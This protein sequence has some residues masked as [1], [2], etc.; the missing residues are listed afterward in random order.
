MQSPNHDPV[1]SLTHCASVYPESHH[2]PHV[3]EVIQDSPLVCA[4]ANILKSAELKLHPLME[5]HSIHRRSIQR[6]HSKHNLLNL[7]LK[8][9]LHLQKASP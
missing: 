6:A 4:S 1:D 9:Q 7:H 5:H 3:H 2:K 8:N